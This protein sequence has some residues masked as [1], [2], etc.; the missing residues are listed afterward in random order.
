MQQKKLMRVF[1]A[2]F[3][4]YEREREKKIRLRM[5]ENEEKIQFGTKSENFT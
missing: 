5:R 2:L 4:I 1:H 3:G